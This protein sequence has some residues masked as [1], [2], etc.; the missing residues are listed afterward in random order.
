MAKLPHQLQ[1]L[2]CP[3]EFRLQFRFTVFQKHGDHLAEILVQL[4]ECFSL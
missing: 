1:R 3:N 4:V 2:V